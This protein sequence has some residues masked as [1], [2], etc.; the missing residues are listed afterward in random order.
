MMALFGLAYRFIMGA[1][2]PEMRSWAL[3]E[4]APLIGL[5]VYLQLTRRLEMVAVLLMSLGLGALVFWT[6]I[7]ATGAMPITS[8]ADYFYI[9]V[10]FAFPAVCVWFGW[11][12]W[13]KAKALTSANGR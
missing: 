2:D 12:Q 3:V 1:L 9:A 8:R 11:Q 13:R 7:L 10:I 6:F 5:F 4:V